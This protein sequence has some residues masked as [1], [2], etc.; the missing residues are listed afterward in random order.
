M[1]LILKPKVSFN[2]WL[3]V[4]LVIIV[5]LVGLLSFVGWQ[6]VRPAKQAGELVS[7]TITPGSSLSEISHLLKASQ[8][9]RHTFWFETW[10]KLSGHEFSLKSGYYSLPSNINVINLTRLLSNA[11][12]NNNETQITIIEGWTIKNIDDYLYQ[13][14]LIRSGEFY[15]AATSRESIGRIAKHIDDKLHLNLAAHNTLEGYLFPDTYRV[16]TTADAEAIIIKLLINFYS[17]FKSSWLDAMTSKKLSVHDVITL[18]SIV[19]REVKTPYDRRMVADIF[20]RRLKQNIPL[21]ADS[22]INYITGK[23]A[24]AVSAQDLAIDSPYNTYKYPGLPPGPISNPGLSA[25]EAV[26]YPTANDYWF[27]L[28]TRD[29]RVIYSRTFNEH[30][31]AKLK[32]LSN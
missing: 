28:T 32:Y 1:F 14:G 11:S 8:L 26:I 9:I 5:L 20:L 19:E 21:Q 16:Y 27:F 22:T 15:A 10:V 30:K 23:S 2:K 25:I 6:F 24:A 29:G 31:A 13:A 18:A 4:G 17:K 7:I 12:F 3:K